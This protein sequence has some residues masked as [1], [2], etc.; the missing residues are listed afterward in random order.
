MSRNA[1]VYEDYKYF[2]QDVAY[3]YVGSKY[4]LEE[5]FQ[6]EDILFRFRKVIAESVIPKADRE[7]T[8]ETVLYYLT[9]D[10]FLVQL[11]KQMGASVRVS[12]LEDKKGLFGK[13]QHK[14]HPEKTYVT[15]FL[16][17]PELA[18]MSAQTKKELGLFVQ[19]LKVSKLAL[20]TV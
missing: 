9:P 5:I 8:L 4:T 13:P 16:S 7:D 18:A 20:L 10:S 12:V 14:K 11:F 17:V 2:M 6:N 3:L 1:T 15:K 19:E